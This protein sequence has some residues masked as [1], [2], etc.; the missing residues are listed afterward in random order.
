MGYG[1][2]RY[3]DRFGGGEDR[4]QGREQGGR[5]ERERGSFGGWGGERDREGGGHRGGGGSRGDDRGFFERA[6]EEVRSWFSDDDD[7]GRGGYQGPNRD[8]GTGGDWGRSSESFGGGFGNQ[9]GWGDDHFDRQ[10]G[11]TQ[12]NRSQGYSG[13]GSR[14]NWGGGGGGAEPWA[15]SGFGGLD[16][17]GRR[18]DRVDAGHV[19]AQGAHPM[20]S[21]VE[22]GYGSRY[23]A[24]GGAYG[25]SSR[26]AAIMANEGQQSGPLIDPQ[27]RDR[28]LGRG[29]GQQ[30]GGGQSGGWSGG[31]H[32]PHYS[33]WR[34]RQ[35][36]QLDRDYEEYRREHQSKFEQDFG[37]WR[38]KRQTQRQHLGRVT[39]KMEVIGADGEHIGTVDKVRGD[40]VILTKSD[41]NAGGI[42]HSFPC[43]WIESVDERVTINKSA[44]EAMSQW[45][46]EEQN[47][48]MF[49]QQG[50]GGEG[51][52]ILNR[53]FSG[54]YSDQDK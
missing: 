4:W 31:H 36:E 20:S 32:D 11:R 38:E 37:G 15:G 53:S 46:N 29:G 49:D 39:E 27:A 43:S 2:N 16:D 33:E 18:F 42:H 34:Q 10:Q 21:P 12:D 41:P 50:Q 40:R 51:P 52:H 47:R 25:S 9:R 13:G 5:W 7:R 28:M 8:R 48:A 14:S 17:N 23:G 30:Q 44:E 45:Q 54:T 3:G 1:D 26:A 35:I 19:G 6:G 22:A 24:S